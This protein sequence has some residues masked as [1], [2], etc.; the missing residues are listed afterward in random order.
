MRKPDPAS[1]ASRTAARVVRGGP[2]RLWTYRDFADLNA[3][4]TAVAAALS[5][6]A[7]A[8]GLRRIRRGVYYRPGTTA[9]G[10]T[11]P[12][13]DAT[14]AA[15]LRRQGVRG[16]AAGLEAWRHLGLTTQV[17]AAP[18]VATS[19]RL[20]LA[21]VA[22]YRVRTTTRPGTDWK[23]RNERAVLD[24]LRSLR[25][26]PDATPEVVLVRLLLL[27][28]SKRLDVPALLKMT[29]GE[30]PRVRALLGALL[31]E[32]GTR[33]VPP[34]ELEELRGSLNPLTT[35]RIPEAV[36]RLKSAAAWNLR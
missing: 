26:I 5:R 3:P 32:A 22:G 30:P 20:R 1:V 11:R 27:L 25:R 34:T 17:N 12:T 18:L 31:E 21:P 23:R 28:R 35:Y 33:I 19:R 2:D 16:V 13:P 10:E 14:L 8:G 15:S 9:F 29:S 4:T 6:L 36:G 24:A 7:R